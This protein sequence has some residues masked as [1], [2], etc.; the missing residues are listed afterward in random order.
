MIFLLE[1][2]RANQCIMVDLFLAWRKNN[3]RDY[4]LQTKVFQK[5]VWSMFKKDKRSEFRRNKEKLEF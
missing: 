1:V 5:F 3:V 2:E 4:L